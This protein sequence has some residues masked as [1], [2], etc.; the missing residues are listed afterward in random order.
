MRADRPLSA[1]SWG[2]PAAVAE[3]LRPEGG[4]VLVACGA[5]DEALTLLAAGAGHVLAVD[6]D[7]G[8]LALAE[9]KLA[10]ARTLPAPTLRSLLGLDAAG[11]R[12]FL[13]HYVRDGRIEGR[14]PLPPG[15]EGPSRAWWDAREALLR[16]GISQGWGPLDKAG[17]ATRAHLRRL[18]LSADIRATLETGL[19]PRWAGR[20]WSLALHRGLGPLLSG[21]ALDRL[22]QVLPARARDGDPRAWLLL[23]GGLPPELSPAPWLGPSALAALRG[24]G[25]LVLQRG[26]LGPILAAQPPGQLDA[27]CLDLAAAGL[28]LAHQPPD[29][30]LL[31]AGALALRPGGRLL[32]RPSSGPAPTRLPP[33]LRPDA[34]A[35]RRLLVRDLA[36]YGG[37]PGVF[38]R[39]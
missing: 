25:R 13:Y 16:T 20:R 29:V 39:T 31:A 18:G 3:A 35:A 27:V 7:P 12:L 14:G 21:A 26:A 19:A 22:L 2:D 9:L 4:R 24:S 38:Q 6:P 5:G 15:L 8:P 30:D 17:V 33:T 11:R 34:D 23:T 1:W 32:F 28:P 37:A 36:V 10:A